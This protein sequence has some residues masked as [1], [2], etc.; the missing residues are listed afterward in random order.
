MR[1]NKEKTNEEEETDGKVNR[2]FGKE[3]FVIAA[4]AAAAN[5]NNNN[6]LK[7]VKRRISTSTLLEN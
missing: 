4:A 5:N 7:N 6:I 2:M 1:E 3:V